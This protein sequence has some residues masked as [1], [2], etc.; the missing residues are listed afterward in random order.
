M[1]CI[2]CVD[3]LRVAKGNNGDWHDK[4]NHK[5]GNEIVSEDKRR[6]VSTNE[7]VFAPNLI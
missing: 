6:V 3:N 5:G 1:N 4:A 7:F 2:H